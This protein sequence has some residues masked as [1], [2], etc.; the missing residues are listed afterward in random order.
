M[1]LEKEFKLECCPMNWP[2]GD[3][4]DFQVSYVFVENNNDYYN[5]DWLC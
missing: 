4:D 3:G 1:Q 5:F 2:I